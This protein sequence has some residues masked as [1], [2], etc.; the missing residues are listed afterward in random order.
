[1]RLEMRTLGVALAAARVR[2]G[3]DGDFLPAKTPLLALLGGTPQDRRR[4]AVLVRQMD[5]G[6]D[7]S[8]R[9]RAV[10]HGTAGAKK[11]R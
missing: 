2:A 1:M 7:G 8:W 6:R 10:R 9:E 4:P 11:V 3:V 5:F